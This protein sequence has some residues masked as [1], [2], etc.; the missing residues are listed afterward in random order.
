MPVK[1]QIAVSR[2]SL[3]F[4]KNIH[5]LLAVKEGELKPPH[6]ALGNINQQQSNFLF[7]N[8]KN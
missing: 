8:T 7:K 3:K 2:A 4:Q 1:L 5:M 6:R